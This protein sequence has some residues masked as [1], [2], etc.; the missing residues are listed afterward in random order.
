M[1]VIYPGD[2]QHRLDEPKGQFPSSNRPN[3]NHMESAQLLAMAL[4]PIVSG[5]LESVSKGQKEHE[6]GGN[7][8]VKDLVDALKKFIAYDGDFRKA[9][10]GYFPTEAQL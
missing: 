8:P 7:S 10:A 4:C 6:P 3:W 2:F 1:A 9:Y 5:I